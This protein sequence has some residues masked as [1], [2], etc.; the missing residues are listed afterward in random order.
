M[1]D[2][3]SSETLD[4]DLARVGS[5]DAPGSIPHPE[6]HL[7][8]PAAPA[9]NPPEPPLVPSEAAFAVFWSLYGPTAL[10]VG[11]GLA[12]VAVVLVTMGNS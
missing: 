10:L 8:V 12:I 2:T 6:H 7:G 1:S 9:T 5:P 3:S 11:L 4:P